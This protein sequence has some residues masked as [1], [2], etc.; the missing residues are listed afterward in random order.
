[1]RTHVGKFCVLVCLAWLLPAT[2]QTLAAPE[3]LAPPRVK[4]VAE[5][6]I[7]F[8]SQVMEIL[9]LYGAESEQVS[10][11][12]KFSFAPDGK[13]LTGLDIG[14]KVALWD[15]ATGK[16]IGGFGAGRAKALALAP[17]GKKLVLVGRS[18]NDY[19]G[20]GGGDAVELWDVAKGKLIKR[21]DEGANRMNFTAVAF[22]P[23]G[24]TLAL[25]ASQAQGGPYP[26]DI[27]RKP[28]GHPV[29]P[30]PGSDRKQRNHAIHLWD[31]STGEELRQIDGPAPRQ[32]KPDDDRFDYDPTRRASHY[33]S[34]L[35]SP[36]GRTLAL[37]SQDNVYLW[38]TATGKQRGMLQVLHL[39]PK[40]RN[41]MFFA[42]PLVNYCLAFAPDG[43][44]IALGSP[45]GV[46]RQWDLGRG[47]ELPPLVGHK[48]PVRGVGYSADGKSLWSIGWDTKLYT[49]PTSGEGLAWKPS[50]AKLTD[51]D[52]EALWKNLG[53]SEALAHY[54]AMQV[55]AASPPVSVPFLRKQIKP[56]S[57]AEA[58][59]V[60]K[61]VET[62]TRHQ[63]YNER[64]KAA[65]E[66]R[67]L[68]E[69]ALPALQGP[70]GPGGM[71][72]TGL[73][74]LIEEDLRVSGEYRQKMAALQVL[75]MIGT[76]EA[77]KLLS[78]LASG[79]AE[80]RLTLKAKAAQERLAA[81]SLAGRQ[82]AL[83]TL[84][85][86]LAGEDSRKAL[87]AVRALT[88]V[89][90]K[91]VPFLQDQLGKLAARTVFE[92]DPQRI[93][94]LI[95]QLDSDNF[96][97][98]ENASKELGKLGPLA[99]PAMRQALDRAGSAEAKKRLEELIK[100]AGQAAPLTEKLRAGRAFEVLEQIGSPEA[101]KVF[102]ALA[103]DAKNASLRE[104]AAD[105]L[106]RMSK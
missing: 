80:A 53:S 9:D 87:L 32:P 30:P 65:I 27:D 4:P 26:S 83:D 23:D 60:Q 67:K 105:A 50:Q 11:L 102:E 16:R 51:Q 84:W 92:D 41:E 38:E 93:A 17:D 85:A 2:G 43:R 3:D 56:A 73:A 45:D 64:R 70:G 5:V 59:H 95:D 79:A 28:N 66:V 31:A 61:L 104:S 68:G 88:A 96:Q 34:M 35:F 20:Y 13:T 40:K 89:P 42:E 98:R 49:W 97:T 48:G 99:A 7:D 63:D 47:R 75:E 33:E 22:S 12:V 21:L 55:L 72:L 77:S 69:A 71:P 6:T 24:K 103:K 90:D 76:E 94:Q 10:L 100:S 14:G 46:V 74:E 86:D 44:K 82:P 39:P 1:M 37:V 62:L 54:G 78:E 52:L 18:F 106:K 58:G 15:P 36:D 91:S 25:G 29:E 8:K 19:S 81:G 101:R 57:A